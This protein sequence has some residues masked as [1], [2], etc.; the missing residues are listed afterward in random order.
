MIS[1]FS[2]I[3]FYLLALC[4]SAFIT[5]CEK[6]E[7]DDHKHYDVPTTYVFTD[8]SGNS[9]VDYTGQTQRLD[10]LTEMMT[11]VKTANTSGVTLDAQKL[12]DMY[13]NQ[14]AQFTGAGLNV[15]DKQIKDKVFAPDQ[16]LFEQ[17]FDSIAVASQSTSVAVNGIAGVGD[18]GTNKYLFSANGIEYTQFIEKGLM[19]ALIYY[20]AVAVY[21]DTDKMSVDNT[22]VV[23]G[24]FYTQLEHHWDEAFGY[25]GVPVDFPSTTTGSRYWG[26]YCSDRN[27]LL[28]TN[29]KLMDAFLKGRAAIS[30]DDLDTR[31]GQIAII[32]EEWEHVVAGTAVHY[33]NGSKNDFADDALRNHQLSEGYAFILSLK[34]NPARKVTIQQI[35]YWLELLG[36]NF[37]EVTLTNINTVRDEISVV[38]GFE[39]MKEQL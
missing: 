13:A 36:D 1:K 26:K 33:M 15:S 7:D 2:R 25:F 34:Y 23:S 19:G 28:G 4:F 24:K 6:E 9:T 32:R 30:N 18:N 31:D 16:G 29:Q 12:K 11:Y 37:Y 3:Q 5:S 14:N 8:S 17:Y 20:Q 27:T 35:D 38:Y 22:T 10:M 21:L 39:S